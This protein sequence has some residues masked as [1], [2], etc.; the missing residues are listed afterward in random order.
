M[1]CRY[2]PD[3]PVVFECVDAILANHDKPKILVVDSASPD[4]SY[5]DGL[6][7]RG[8]KIASIHNQLYA[9]GAHAWAYRHYPD[10]EYFYMI[11][12]SLIV[13]SNLDHLQERP[14]TV[15]RHWPS[16]MHD[17]GW[18][19]DGT[20]LS[21]WGGE[22]LA[23]MGI[24]MPDFYNGIMGP[25]M[26]VQQSVCMQLDKLGYWFT[27]TT[28][29]YKQCAME[30]VAGITLEHLGYDVTTSLQ[31]WHTHHEARYDETMVKKLNLGRA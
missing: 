17:W 28:S 30:R 4:K 14:V 2:D 10:I 22:Q 26:M 15:T 20:H 13:Q 23:R 29:A 21:V 6:M 11:F 1:P 8:V 27:Q 12:D 5:F 9:V 24:P 3:R 31:G 19:A 18:D 16:T 25:M 7:D